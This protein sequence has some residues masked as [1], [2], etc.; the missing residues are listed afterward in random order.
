MVVSGRTAR[1]E[2]KD[3]PFLD[4]L[5]TLGPNT[6]AEF[7]QERGFTVS[8]SVAEQFGIGPAALT[9][10]AGGDAKT[11]AQIVLCILR[12]EDR[13]PKRDAVLLNAAAGLFVADRVKTLIEGWELAA[14]II[15]RG[16]AIEKLESL[17]TRGCAA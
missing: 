16:A 4:E 5:S 17:R 2:I 14:R 11:N 3:A 12:G 10:L 6:I 7:Y 1:S 8:E 13:G 15:D 9:D